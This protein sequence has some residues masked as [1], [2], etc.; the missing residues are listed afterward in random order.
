MRL[1]ALLYRYT[2]QTLAETL[3]SDDREAG[4]FLAGMCWAFVV[5]WVLIFLVSYAALGRTP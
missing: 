5:F 1:V 2:A 3:P 4:V